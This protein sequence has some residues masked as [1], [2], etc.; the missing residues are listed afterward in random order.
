MFF[1]SPRKRKILYLKLIKQSGSPDFVA[2]GVAIGFFTGLLIPF[3]GQMIIAVILSF[4]FKASKIPALA[5]T[6]I[7]NPWTIPFI[8]PFQCWLGAKLM[9]KTLSFSLIKDNFQSFLHEC[10]NGT[11]KSTLDAFLAMGS[12]IFIPFFVGGLF[13]GVIFGVA[14]YFTAYGMIVSYHKKKEKKLKKRLARLAE[15]NRT[16]QVGS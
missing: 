12:D 13:L 9:G 5:C 11:F 7:T 15:K 6:W 14:S 16:K 1:L 2:R 3:G 8:Y 4:I 10:A